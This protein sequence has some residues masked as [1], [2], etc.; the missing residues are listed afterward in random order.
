MPGA[1]QVLLEEHARIRSVVVPALA[2]GRDR[3]DHGDSAP[4]E[5]YP[6]LQALAVLL[7]GDLARHAAKEDD[8]L[9]PAIESRLGPG[10]GPTSV[11][12]EEHRRIH[13]A[14]DTFRR[15]LEAAGTPAVAGRVTSDLKTSLADLGE[16]IGVHFAKEEGVLFPMAESIL[17]P[18]ELA[19]LGEQLLTYRG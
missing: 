13:V 19:S 14:G 5:G 9:F 7:E 1:I 4:G 15:A 16:L 6:S 8:V 12:R 2:A 3:Q 10:E 11:M 18:D 17:S